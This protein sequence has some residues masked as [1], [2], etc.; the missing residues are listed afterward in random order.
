MRVLAATLL[1]LSVPLAAGVSV[2]AQTQTPAAQT[3]DAK[4]F[5][6]RNAWAEQK[7]D[8]DG[9]VLSVTDL[10]AD[11]ADKGRYRI[12]VRDFFTGCRIGD[13]TNTVCRVGQHASVVGGALG[14]WSA[15]DKGADSDY[16]YM[17]EHIWT[18]Q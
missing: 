18:C 8:I 7:A 11:H 4:P 12:V 16:P 2:R 9:P 13:N 17:Q 15:D 1:A 6:C 14:D 5:P 3:D 10:G